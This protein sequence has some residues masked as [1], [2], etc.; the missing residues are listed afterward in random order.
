MT[1]KEVTVNPLA[2]R[3]AGSAANLHVKTLATMLKIHEIDR[4]G[5]RIGSRERRKLV[6]SLPVALAGSKIDDYLKDEPG[7]PRYQ[8]AQL[9]LTD[10]IESTSLLNEEVQRTVVAGAE[11]FKVVRNAGCAM[12]Q[13]KSNALRVPLGE[14]QINAPV[15]AEGAPIPDRTQDYSFRNFTIQKYGM[16]PRISYEM[17]ED[18][19][20]EAVAEEIF[21]AGAAVENKLNID[22]ITNCI[23]N[24][25][26]VNTY[27][28]GRTSA[29]TG[30]ALPNLLQTKALMKADGFIADTI[31]MCSDM[32]YDL[33]QNGNIMQAMQFGSNVAISGGQLPSRL[34]GMNTFVTD[35]GSTTAANWRYTTDN[36]TAA[37]MLEAKRGLGIAMRRDLTVNKFDDIEKELHTI[38]ATM[39]C[40]VSYLHANAVGT[41]TYQSS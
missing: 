9:L 4:K 27:A 41:V 23:A 18:G 2:H 25:G 5:E 34:L 22:A 39:R 13:T 8:A 1:E 35:N 33:L 15:V 21:F 30:N 20:I 31:I 26:N 40:A 6:N 24:K 10:A 37:V 38:T 29:T 16:K 32:E 28:A 7:M 12:Y 11:K 3:P 17:V 36:D 19:L 14:A